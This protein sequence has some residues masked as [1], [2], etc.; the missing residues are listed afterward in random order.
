[1]TP[2]RSHV[3]LIP[4]FDSGP[5]LRETV[6]AAAAHWSPL[7][8]VVDGS[9][10]GSDAGLE[11]DGL[12]V[13]RRRDNRGKGEAVRCGLLHAAGAGFSHALVMDADGQHP[14]DEIGAM[15]AAS[16]VQPGAMILGQP[17]FGQ[18]A[19]WARV[20]GRRLGNALTAML[21]AGSGVGDSLF[22]FRVYPI[23]PLLE[24]MGE[25]RWMRGFDF[26]TEAI[27]R[28]SWR[29]VVAVRR[30]VPVRYPRPEQGGVSHF[31]YGRDNLLLAWM[32]LRLLVQ[33]LARRPAAMRR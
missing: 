26:D 2:S 10:D 27:V 30:P 9:R 1:M 6:A 28:L 8:V 11:A 23:G 21:T 29:G 25:T 3:V 5:L 4:S 15:M 17:Q 13:L 19:P 20:R 16:A 24:V 32:Y 22:G 14:A 33:W 18:D 31:R 7:L 12:T